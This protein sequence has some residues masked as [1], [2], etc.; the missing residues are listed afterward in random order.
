V[1]ERSAWIF[2]QLLEEVAVLTDSELNGHAGV[3]AAIDPAWLAGRT[4]AELIGIDA[5]DHYPMH[6][7]QLK[8]AAA[9]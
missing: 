8:S 3:T 5:F 7:S 9:S 6:F 1:L 4:L 2:L